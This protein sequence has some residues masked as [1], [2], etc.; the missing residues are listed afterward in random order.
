MRGVL[1]LPN[2]EN[3]PAAHQLSSITSIS[4]TR[5]TMDASLE[6]GIPKGFRPMDVGP[7]TTAALRVSR[8]H[9][10]KR[11]LLGPC[12]LQFHQP[13]PPLLSY[14]IGRCIRVRCGFLKG[15]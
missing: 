15:S 10:R 14:L 1:Y 7:Q 5:Q 9:S 4:K 12:R 8:F 11:S 13:P 2:D 3:L 6:D